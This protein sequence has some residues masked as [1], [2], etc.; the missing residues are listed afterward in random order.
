[1]GMKEVFHVFL[2]C[3]VGLRYKISL[4]TAIDYAPIAK[5]LDLFGVVVVAFFT[6]GRGGKRYE[7]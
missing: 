5:L 4:G 1:M 3:Y 6:V 7:V 2:L